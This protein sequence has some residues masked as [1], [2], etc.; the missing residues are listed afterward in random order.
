[1]KF[2]YIADT[3]IGCR[4]GV[5]Y[6]MQP[7]YGG[8]C[9][10]ELFSVLA[11]WV[12]R[13]GGVDFVLHGGDMVDAWSFENCALAKAYLAGMPCPV[14]LTPGNHDLTA[15]DARGKW[16]EYA[17]EFFPDGKTE[18]SFVCD[19]VRFDMI[20]SHWGKTR[21][22]WDPAEAQIPWFSEE[23]LEGLQAG[24]VPT[25]R[26]IVSH[27]PPCGVPPGQ[28]G[29]ENPVHS[30]DEDFEKV[31]ETLCARH[32]PVLWLGAHNHMNLLSV[33][34]RTR[35][36]TCPA[37]TETPFEFKLFEIGGGK[38]AMETI[39]LRDKVSFPARYDDT[40]SYVQGRACDRAFSIGE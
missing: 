34:G 8:A 36:V 17:P 10:D 30:P 13:Q 4:E 9:M 24:P 20:T 3:H 26:V 23:Q 33:A 22:F 25:Q 14:Y 15:P 6:Q 16:L 31:V 5:G 18:A 29:F 21:Y 7:R 28:T 19:G 38:A 2:V 11:D 39:S 1:M 35:L 12:H 32:V 37:L 27:A 40:R